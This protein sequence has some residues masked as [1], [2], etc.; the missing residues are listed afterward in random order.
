MKAILIDPDN[1][2][3]RML[4]NYNG[5]FVGGD[6]AYGHIGCSCIE[7]VPLKDDEHHVLL[8]DEEGKLKSGMRGC[9]KTT[10]FPYDVIVGKAMIV[11]PADAE[12]EITECTLDV[13]AVY[14]TI[15]WGMTAATL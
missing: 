11:G 4:H 2:Q 13:K 9:F 6:G 3:V 7:V 12:G 8:V 10:L 15:E 1:Q 14:A 5:Q